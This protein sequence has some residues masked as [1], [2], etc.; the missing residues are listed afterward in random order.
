M[1]SSR[2]LAPARARNATASRA[3][4]DRPSSS[5][6]KPASG[7][8]SHG[9]SA[10]RTS[11]IGAARLGV[12]PGGP[13]RQAPPADAAREAERVEPRRIVADDARRK[14]RAL[15]GA[16]RRFEALKVG[17]HARQARL[18]VEL[19]AGPDV[20]PAEEEAQEVGG[21]DRLDLAAQAVE[22]VPVDAREQAPIAPLRR[23]VGRADA[24]AAAQRRPLHLEARQRGFDVGRA[25]AQPRCDRVRRRRTQQA[26]G[27]RARSRRARFLRRA[28][29]P[30]ATAARPR[31]A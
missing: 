3:A 20:L 31:P 26:R 24:E 10:R 19:A 11:A 21:A 9:R 27:D 18:A 2:K 29:R 4:G 14:D 7:V 12:P 23:L 28:A 25:D 15:P 13:G 1:I 30:G 6:G 22:H 17:D 8:S 16:G 5:A